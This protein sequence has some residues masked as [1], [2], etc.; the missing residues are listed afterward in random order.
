MTS[1]GYRAVTVAEITYTTTVGDFRY[2]F[3]P[4]T[5]DASGNTGSIDLTDR[6]KHVSVKNT[7]VRLTT[8]SHDVQASN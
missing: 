8:Q 4:M 5:N 1:T 6:I 7:R 2:A 3:E